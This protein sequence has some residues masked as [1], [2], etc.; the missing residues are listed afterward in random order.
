M[1]T[2]AK[3]VD[4]MSTSAA[5]DVLPGRVIGAAAGFIGALVES[6]GD[7]TMGAQQQLLLLALYIHG[8]VNMMDL[9]KFTGVEKS[10]NSRNVAVLGSGQ[11]IT[12]RATGA[13][14]FEEGPGLVEAYEEPT[15][16]R[17]KMVRLTPKGRAV[18]EAAASQAA[19]FFRQ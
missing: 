18:L 15:N 5:K 4:T 6:V 9:P 11:W 2:V 19:P 16:R 7:H 17:F 13:K 10:A 1:P 8:N 14:R 12:D 3:K